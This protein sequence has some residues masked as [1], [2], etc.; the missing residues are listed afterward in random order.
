MAQNG[1]T[2]GL[3]SHEPETNGTKLPHI[4][5]HK[6]SSKTIPSP[7]PSTSKVA[8]HFIGSNHLEAA[9]PSDV[10]DFVQSHEGHTVITKVCG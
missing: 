3:A 1:Y 4:N 7:I 6:S 5:G 2:N 10:K 8:A 9:P